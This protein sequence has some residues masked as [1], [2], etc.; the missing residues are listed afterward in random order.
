MLIINHPY[1][2]K[3]FYW[4]IIFIFNKAFLLF[5]LD[6][7]IGHSSDGSDIWEKFSCD[8]KILS[9]EMRPK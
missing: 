6:Y 8:A 4:R 7:G 1:F 3:Y 2:N 9:S 5:V